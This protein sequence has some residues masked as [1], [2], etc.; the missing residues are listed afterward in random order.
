MVELTVPRETFH[1]KKRKGMRGFASMDPERQRAIASQGGKRAHELGTAHQF[2]PEEARAA[3]KKAHANG[4]TH[5]FT[6]AEAAAAGRIGGQR[7]AQQ[8][9]DAENTDS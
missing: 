9:R 7:R 1:G 4:K 3:G 2:T 6:S 5:Q 8:V